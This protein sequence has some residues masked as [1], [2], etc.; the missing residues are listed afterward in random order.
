MMFYLILVIVYIVPRADINQYCVNKSPIHAC[1]LSWITELPE[2]DRGHLAKIMYYVRNCTKFDKTDVVTKWLSKGKRSMSMFLRVLS[3]GRIAGN[4][5]RND[6]TLAVGYDVTIKK[7][8][9][10]IDHTADVTVT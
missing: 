7:H 4:G 8:L 3:S 1:S 10:C 2:R 5:N 9:I 6:V